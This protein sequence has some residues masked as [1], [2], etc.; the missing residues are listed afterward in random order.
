MYGRKGGEAAGLGGQRRGHQSGHACRLACREFV[1]A[2]VGRWA[3]KRGCGVRHNGRA[4]GGAMYGRKDDGERSDSVRGGVTT[5]AQGA[6]EQK[7]WGELT[8]SLKLGTTGG[9]RKI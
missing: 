1:R 5:R 3:E 4:R 7:F 9:C 2:S 8:R 6:E